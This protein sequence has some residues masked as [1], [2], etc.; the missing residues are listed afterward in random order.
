MLL[1]VFVSFT[2]EKKKYIF[3]VEIYIDKKCWSI[4]F[5]K[6]YMSSIL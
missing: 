3:T 2:L 1:L 6:F 5:Q 4:L